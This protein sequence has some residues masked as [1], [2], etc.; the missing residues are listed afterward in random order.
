LFDR[1]PEIVVFDFAERALHLGR[2]RRRRRNLPVVL[3]LL[4]SLDA[5]EWPNAEA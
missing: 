2:E 5:I 1:A 4:N 3:L